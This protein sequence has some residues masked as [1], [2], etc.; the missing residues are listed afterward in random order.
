MKFFK[1]ELKRWDFDDKFISNSVKNIF[2]CA[3]NVYRYG[4]IK[5]LYKRIIK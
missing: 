4:K 3:L 5:L 1:F 2:L